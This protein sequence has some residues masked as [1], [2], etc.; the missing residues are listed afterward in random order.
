MT[1][2]AHHTNGIDA[3]LDRQAGNALV[4][5]GAVV[6]MLR[7]AW[8]GL[9][10]IYAFGSRIQNTANPESDLDLAVL[11]PT[12]VPPLQLWELASQLSEVVGCPVDLL[13]FRAT[14]TVMQHQVLTQGIR[15]Y[16]SGSDAGLFECF[17]LS[18]KTALDAARAGVLG[19]IALQ[20]KVYG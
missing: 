7:A 18:E 6:R 8:P 15:L 2:P 11:V 16:A 12:Y 4:K 1:T 14:S 17:V 13:D 10:A 20:G 5:D 19:D 9:L 3:V